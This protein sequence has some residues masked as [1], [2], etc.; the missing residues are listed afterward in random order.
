MHEL[1]ESLELVPRSQGTLVRMTKRLGLRDSAELEQDS[2]R[3][4]C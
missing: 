4:A 3:L 1:M 2:E